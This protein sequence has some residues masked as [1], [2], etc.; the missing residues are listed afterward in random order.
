MFNSMTAYGRSRMSRD[1]KDITV[2][3][4]SVNS[5]GLD[6][7]V[8]MP[9]CYSA[10][11]ERVRPYLVGRGITRGKVDV[12][13]S[14][15]SSQSDEGQTLVLDEG[16]ATAYIAALRQLRDRFGLADD[17]ST[18]TV[19]QNREL[20]RT[21]KPEQDAERD[22]QQLLPAISEA[23]DRFLAASAAEGARLEADMM[24]KLEHIA[25][26]V[27]KIAGLSGNDI[28]GY[29]GRL[30][31]KL[32]DILADNRITVDENR[33]L[34]ECAIAADRLAVDEEVVRLRSHIAYFREICRSPE[35]AGKRLEYQLMEMNREVNTI[36]SK[37]QNTDI[38]RL[39]V[40]T[41]NEL[42]KI[43]EQVQNIA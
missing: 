14:V 1:E 20:F 28:Q 7:S 17:I 27:E 23:V 43:R 11:E 35:P 18:M 2:E 9:R 36:G 41:K 26:N 15:E 30:E 10:L 22:W 38:S 21:T 5:R 6:C 40:D 4:R 19:A 32:R 33:L 8:R 16:Y 39:V 12:F 24:S 13:I 31:Q 37:C 3:L 34:T 29:R 25:G 42:E